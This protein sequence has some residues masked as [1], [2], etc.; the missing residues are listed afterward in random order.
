MRVI[1][2][3]ATGMV[4]EGVLLTALEHPDVEMVLAVGRRPS[5]VQHPRR[6]DL[7]HGDFFDW[8]G[9]RNAVTGYDACFF[10]LGTSS[11]GMK[12]EV[13]ERTTYDLTLAVA[14]TLVELN[15]SM[16]FAYVSGAGTDSSERGRSRWARVKGRTE[17]A[18]AR[19]PF[20]AVHNFRPGMI[21]PRP[22]QRRVSLG[23]RFLT[24]PFPVWKRLFP[25]QTSTV[26][27]IALAM[28]RALREGD[29]RRVLEV[30]AIGA[31]AAI[32]TGSVRSRM[33]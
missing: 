27:E 9:S 1:V 23:M 31:L 13:Y 8:S 5:G 22:D 10:C 29:P 26:V 19:L 33:V 17:N 32:E 30:P 2:F 12:P 3:G 6:L 11:V 16:T 28:I 15:P 18:L 7:V 14:R 20:R 25:R 21:R 24:W 4:G